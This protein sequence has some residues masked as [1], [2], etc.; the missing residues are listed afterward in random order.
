MRNG[1]H[2]HYFK[3]ISNKRKFSYSGNSNGGLLLP[4][5]IK[6]QETWCFVIDPQLIIAGWSYADLAQTFRIIQIMKLRFL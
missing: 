3:I 2:I 4:Y 5:H 6:E 1:S